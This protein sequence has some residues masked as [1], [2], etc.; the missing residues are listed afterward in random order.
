MQEQEWVGGGGNSKGS[1]GVRD[2]EKMLASKQSTRQDHL[3]KSSQFTSTLPNPAPPGTP[4]P[5]R[6][7]AESASVQEQLWGMTLTA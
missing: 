6:E 7:W 1:G 2:Q 3:I 4:K 5:E